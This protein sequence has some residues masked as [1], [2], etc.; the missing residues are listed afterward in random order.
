MVKALDPIIIFRL[1]LDNASL[2]DRAHFPE[3][4]TPTRCKVVSSITKELEPKI[5]THF[6][7]DAI[8]YK[9]LKVCSKWFISITPQSMLYSL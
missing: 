1:E 2:N 6:L 5:L 3:N 7:E 9:R 8:N 4:K